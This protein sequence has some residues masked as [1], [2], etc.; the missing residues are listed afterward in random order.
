MGGTEEWRERGK[1][2]TG[3]SRENKG[4]KKCGTEEREGN[5]RRERRIEGRMKEK[6][7]AEGRERRGGKEGLKLDHRLQQ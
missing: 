7:K 2:G 5:E 6:N 1:V 3:K 4:E